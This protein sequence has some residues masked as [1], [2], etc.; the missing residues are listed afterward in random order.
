MVD[1]TPLC[2]QHFHSLVILETAEVE[3]WLTTQ[4]GL[5]QLSP[6]SRRDARAAVTVISRSVTGTPSMGNSLVTDIEIM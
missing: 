3:Q 2:G 5:E 4:D 1:P 6:F